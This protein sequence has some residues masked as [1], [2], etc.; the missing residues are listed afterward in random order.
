[1]KKKED[2]SDWDEVDKEL[3]SKLHII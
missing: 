1:M 2:R 3:V